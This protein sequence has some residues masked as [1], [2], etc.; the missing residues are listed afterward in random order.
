M[1]EPVVLSPD[2]GGCWSESDLFDLVESIRWFRGIGAFERHL[3]F[4]GENTPHRDLSDEMFELVEYLQMNDFVDDEIL[5]YRSDYDDKWTWKI[6]ASPSSFAVWQ[7]V[8]F[9]EVD[10]PAA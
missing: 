2:H 8:A 5:I 1:K 4:I 9:G 10:N 7:N 3:K 6:C